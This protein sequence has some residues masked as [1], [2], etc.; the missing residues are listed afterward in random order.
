[1]DYGVLLLTASQRE[2]DEEKK[3]NPIPENFVFYY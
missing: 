1:M 2:D 3:E